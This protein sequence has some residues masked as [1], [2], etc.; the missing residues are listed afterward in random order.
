MPTCAKDNKNGSI[1]SL[2][3][4]VGGQIEVIG[5]REF[6]GSYIWDSN[7]DFNALKGLPNAC[8]TAFDSI[9]QMRSTCTEVSGRRT[10]RGSLEN[11]TL[12][13]SV[14]DES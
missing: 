8:K 13:K 6:R 1:S 2:L 14:C 5:S 9:G 7:S 10:Y 11:A 3:A 4:W 12:K